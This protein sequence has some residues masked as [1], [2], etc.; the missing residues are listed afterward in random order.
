MSPLIKDPITNQDKNMDINKYQCLTPDV[1]QFLP[2]IKRL[3]NEDNDDNP[4]TTD[5]S[6]SDKDNMSHTSRDDSIAKVKGMKNTN[7]NDKYKE[8]TSKHQDG[9]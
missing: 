7:Y 2:G 4:K 8:D 9:N 3:L 5:K 1:P 6:Q